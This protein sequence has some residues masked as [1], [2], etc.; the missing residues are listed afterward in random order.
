MGPHKGGKKRKGRLTAQGGPL[1]KN[2]KMHA[3]RVRSTPSISKKKG[4][5]EEG[6]SGGQ[7]GCQGKG[8]I[9]FLGDILVGFTVCRKLNKK[10][11][12]KKKDYRCS[13]ATPQCLRS[14]SSKVHGGPQ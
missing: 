12:K 7:M 8:G 6:I 9:K 5:R 14:T 13:P 1:R 2:K 3:G 11:K 4:K 10:E